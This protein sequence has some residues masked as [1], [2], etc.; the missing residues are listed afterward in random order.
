MKKLFSITFII[1]LIVLLFDKFYSLI[2]DDFSI[3]NL[4]RLLVV[5]GFLIWFFIM[6]KN[7]K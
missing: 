2:T 1:F 5:L 3:L 7:K 6:I 4:I